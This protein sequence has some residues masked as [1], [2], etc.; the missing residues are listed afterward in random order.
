MPAL[1]DLTGKRFSR[2]IVLSRAFKSKTLE[3]WWNC[4][5]DCGKEKVIRGAALKKGIQGTGG[6]QSCGCLRLER[7][8]KYAH[9][10]CH[11]ERKHVAHGRCFPCD[12]AWRRQTFKAKRCADKYGIKDVD[13]VTRILKVEACQLC[14]ATEQLHVDHDH[15][16]GKVRGRLCGRHNQGLGLFQDN[17]RLLRK[18]ALYLEQ[19]L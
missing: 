1:I 16:T 5:C 8:I 17:P 11:P 18:A 14:G 6:T 10:L 7:I 9:P 2:L 3:T 19:T 12:Q 4:R 13:A 15:K